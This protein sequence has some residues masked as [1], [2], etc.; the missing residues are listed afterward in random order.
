MGLST[1]ICSGECNEGTY[2][3]SGA[4]ICISCS[5][6]TYNNVSA[7]SNCESCSIGT[8]SSESGSTICND[9]SA[10]KHL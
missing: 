9:C 5:I 7:S 2:S 3:L 6:G 1:S 10:G 8:Y 4:T